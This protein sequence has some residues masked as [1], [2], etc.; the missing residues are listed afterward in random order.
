MSNSTLIYW[1]FVINVKTEFLLLIYCFY[2]F[3]FYILCDMTHLAEMFNYYKV[4]LD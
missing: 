2:C 4:A 3:V 1:V